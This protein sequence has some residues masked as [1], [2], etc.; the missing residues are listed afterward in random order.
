MDKHQIMKIALLGI[1]F[2]FILNLADSPLVAQESGQLYVKVKRTEGQGNG[3]NWLNLTPATA[4]SIMSGAPW[5]VQ[6]PEYEYG[7]S[8][9]LVRVSDPTA[10]KNYDYTLKINPIAANDNSLIDSSAHW[11]LEWSQNGQPLG[12]YTSQHTISEGIEE[13]IMGHGISVLVKNQPFAI[14]DKNLANY[15]AQNGGN[16]Y[17]NNAWYAQPDMIGSA[18]EYSGSNHWLGGLKDAETSTP[19]NWIRS[20]KHYASS[21]WECNSV[22][23]G[24]ECDYLKWRTEDYF[25]LYIPSYEKVR[26]WMDYLGQYENIANGTW[27]PYVMTSAYD[28]GP[29][30]RFLVEDVF[31][32]EVAPSPSYYDFTTLSSIPNTAS[33]NQTLTNLYSVDIVLTPDKSKWTRAVVLEAG[34]AGVEDN[35]LVNQQFN[36]QTYQNIRHEPKNCPSVDKNGN[37]DNSGTTGLGWFPGYAINVETGERLNI[38]FA[39]NSADIYNNGNDMIFNPTDV[40]AFQ[41]DST[42]NLMLD[43]NGQPIPLTQEEYNTLYNSPV[44]DRTKLGEP[45]YGG[46]HYVYIMGSSGNTANLYYRSN[47]QSRNYNDNNQTIAAAGSQYGGTFVGTDGD[48]YPY[49]E[50][51]V[52]DEC[53]WVKQKFSTL[54]ESNMNAMSRKAKK[55]EIF[56]NVMWTGIPMPAEGQESHWLANDATVKIRVSRP[57]MFYSSAVGIEPDVVTNNN[58]P[59][60]TFTTSDMNVARDYALYPLE[61]IL[62]QQGNRID[63]NNVDASVSPRAGAW[64]F[65]DEAD[66]KVPKGTDKSS[67]FCYSL[68]M[69][70]RDEQ[71]SLHVMAER[72]NQTGNDSWPGPLSLA[73][74]SVDESTVLQWDRTFKITRQEVLEFMANYQDPD[75]VI[76]QHILEW[77]AHGDTTKGQAWLLAPFTD[78]DGDNHYDP[79][80]GDH[81]DFPGDMAQFVIFNDNYA[82]HTESQGRPLGVEVHVMVYAYDAPQDSIMNNTLFLNYKIFNRSQHNYKDAYIGLWSDWD[83][84][85]A[86]DD[87]VGCDVM[88]NTAY[89]YNGSA[90]DGDGQAWAYGEQWPV[91][92]LTLLAGPYM[93]ADSLDNPAYTEGAD[94]TPFLFNGLDQY[95][96]NGTGF[97]DGIV[98]NER[99]GMT[100][101]IYHT[102]DNSVTGDPQNAQEYYGLMC[103]CWKDGSHLRYGAN[104]HPS[105]GANGPDCRFMFPSLTD[106]CNWGTNG[107]DPYPTMYGIDGWTEATAGNTPYDRR[108]LASVGPFLLPAGGTQ[109]LDLC[110][111]TI[112][113]SCAVNR[114]GFTLDSLRLVNPEYH[115]QNFITP[116]VVNLDETI[117]EGES[118]TFFGQ[119]CDKTGQYKHLARN[120]EQSNDI[121]DTLYML[122]LTVVPNV[123][124][125]Y[126][127]VL[128]GQTYNEHGFNITSQNTSTP[129]SYIFTQESVSV[130]GCVTTIVLLLDVR[131]DA[132]V[133]EHTVANNLKLYPN[134]TT[135]YVM[136][137]LND[138]QLLQQD[139]LVSVFDIH[140]KLLH[141]QSL[142]DLQ[143]RVD[144]GSYP[145]G[146]YL[147]KVKNYIGKVLKK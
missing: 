147:I 120:V 52:Y 42:G 4:N 143:T 27:A 25:N 43:A 40:F 66:F 30:A 47:N 26:G 141:S 131:L 32:L 79:T 9:I 86:N 51:G 62:E 55:M 3:G 112:P 37:P 103:S 80:H 56:N 90:I 123:T 15:V 122:Q 17:K 88:K 64:F 105:N 63:V 113:H 36:G 76:P 145:S 137:E 41:K 67:Y 130:S 38:M 5:R 34:S 35:Y 59:V 144:L 100:G 16:T 89:C 110:M 118:L 13:E 142:T 108:G 21:K 107:I 83:L 95:A 57:Y 125:Y 45:L 127:D 97:G 49:Y 111:V 87:Y 114:L 128:P 72:F 60:F 106:P 39:E 33:Y 91:Q 121:A 44:C 92:T 31:V 28:G 73:D 19:D 74:G 2:T 85:Y 136:V 98:D 138:E 53:N 116:V 71:D 10:V 18:I 23:A 46:R 77:P 104:G 129:G 93:P 11:I 70:G 134:P 75:Y 115:S 54:I 20:G 101:F 119:T 133:E 96:F 6:Q 61:N 29:K 126:A 102:N 109:E 146:L 99:Y 69:G 68:W 82:P 124:I 22:Q 78:V 58:A 1:L 135:Q 94:C 140:G 84:G 132:S 117:C 81:P 12:S 48:E 24:A 139:E 8:P 14:H 7:T 65:G 50:C